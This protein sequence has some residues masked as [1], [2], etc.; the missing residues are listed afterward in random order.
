[1]MQV[2]LEEPE[3]IT[4]KKKKAIDKYATLSWP[5]LR[6]GTTIRA[7]YSALNMEKLSFGSG[8][9]ELQ[10]KH[11]EAIVLPLMEAA[12]KFPELVQPY[13]FDYFEIKHKFHALHAAYWNNGLFIYIPPHAEIEKPII[14]DRKVLDNSI[15]HVLVVC[16][17]GSNAMII[18]KHSSGDRQQ[19]FSSSAVEAIVKHGAKLTFA[20]V[21]TYGTNVFNFDDK[22]AHVEQDAK[23]E[24]LD[25]CFGS[26]FTHSDVESILNSSGAESKV[27]GLFFGDGEQ[28]F[29]VGARSIHAAPHTRSD[30]A[31]KG[32]LSGKAKA[33]YRGL[34]RIEKEAPSSDGYQKEDVL[35]LSEEAEANS[36][37]QLEIDNNEVKCSHAATTSH[38]DNDQL[39][40]LMSRGIEKEEATK[41][42]VSGFFEA[43]ITQLPGE[44]AADLRLCIDEKLRSNGGA[45]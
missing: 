38:I 15:H 22:I 8:I 43:F 34:V 6:Y 10:F 21:Q 30:I 12:R 4:E 13:L 2:E 20:S 1:M 23:I 28:Q 39:F 35:M 24:W 31:G 45:C 3:W 14:I 37:P 16:G 33:I 36:I 26:R 18:E 25:F 7:D 40:Y 42:I 11:D 29:D 32:V 41:L 5:E 19:L 9:V 44:V 17:E 27:K